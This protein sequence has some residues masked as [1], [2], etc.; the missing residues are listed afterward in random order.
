MLHFLSGLHCWV[1]F[2]MQNFWVQETIYELNGW[3]NNGFWSWPIWSWS[4]QNCNRGMNLVTHYTGV[5][6]YHILNYNNNTSFSS[7]FLFYKY[8]SENCSSHAGKWNWLVP[9]CWIFIYSSAKSRRRICWYG[10]CYLKSRC[11]ICVFLIV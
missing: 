5:I 3:H 4:L 9:R 10:F 1:F 6:C 8:I 11:W 2:N 7:L